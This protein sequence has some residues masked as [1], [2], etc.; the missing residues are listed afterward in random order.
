MVFLQGIV[1]LYPRSVA[2]QM[3]GVH[4]KIC[5]MIH[6]VRHTHC[7]ISVH[8][9]DLRDK[10][11][12]RHPQALTLSVRSERHVRS[13]VAFPLFPMVALRMSD[14]ARNFSRTHAKSRS[15]KLGSFLALHEN[16]DE[17]NFPEIQGKGG[18]VRQG[19]SVHFIF[20][21]GHFKFAAQRGIVIF[22]NNGFNK[23]YFLSF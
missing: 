4:R 12:P 23:R 9:R 21:R 2:E 19:G 20:T 3:H 5:V 1:P 8:L 11:L 17:I 22:R 13:H 6:T 15:G 16:C 18:I 7:I 10:T 14:A